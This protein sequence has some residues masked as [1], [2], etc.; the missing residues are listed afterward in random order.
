MIFLVIWVIV[1]MVRKSC[2]ICGDCGSGDCEQ[3]WKSIGDICGDCGETV[4]IFAA[5]MMLEE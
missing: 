3:G 4:V 5:V 1:V 2:E